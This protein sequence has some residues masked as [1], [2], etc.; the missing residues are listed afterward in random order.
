MADIIELKNRMKS[1]VRAIAMIVILLAI[2]A[3]ISGCVSIPIPN[4]IPIPN[5]AS[6]FSLF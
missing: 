5:S 3:M 2:A 6:M 1:S 4:M